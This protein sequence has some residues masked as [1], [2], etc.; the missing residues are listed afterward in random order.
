MIVVVDL[1]E[2]RRRRLGGD[3]VHVR[4]V[5]LD[6]NVLQEADAAAWAGASLDVPAL[7][8]GGDRCLDLVDDREGF[9]VVAL[10]LFEA[11]DCVVDVHPI[12]ESSGAD[13]S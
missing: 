5:L 9:A 6:R 3:V 4:E 8:A 10:E 12:I 13:G 1:I 7:E 2:Y 11:G